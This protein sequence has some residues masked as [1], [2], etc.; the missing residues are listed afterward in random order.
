MKE[1]RIKLTKNT[2]KLAL[3]N[4][5]KWISCPRHFKVCSKWK[6]ITFS[7]ENTESFYKLS[8]ENPASNLICFLQVQIQ[9]FGKNDSLQ[10]FE[11]TSSWVTSSD[12][13]RYKK[14][15]EYNSPTGIKKSTWSFLIPR[16]LWLLLKKILEKRKYQRL[17][18]SGSYYNAPLH[19]SN[20]LTRICA[21]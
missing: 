16:V 1:W 2:S 21:S 6:K 18:T 7:D 10:K 9:H 13:I 14:H 3:F 15:E 4:R 12:E 11:R 19:I 5:P 8:R 20:F 17:S